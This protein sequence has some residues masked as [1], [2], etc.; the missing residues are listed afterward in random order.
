MSGL[1]QVREGLSKAWDTVTIG[2]RELRELAGDALC[3]ARKNSRARKPE[4]ITMSWSVRTGGSSALASCP[5][6]STTSRPGR[7]I[8]TAC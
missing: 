5:R 3:A 1:E 7:A 8:A 6:P 4:A 2:W